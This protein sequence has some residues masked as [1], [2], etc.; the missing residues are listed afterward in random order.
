MKS[1][2]AI[3]SNFQV[4][5]KSSTTSTYELQGVEVLK[6]TRTRKVLESKYELN[7]ETNAKAVV[8]KDIK[9]SE[10]T[11]EFEYPLVEIT[12]E[13]LAEYRKSN[14]PSIVFKMDGKL[15]YSKIPKKMNLVSSAILGP[16]VCAVNDRE[17]GRHYPVSE[18]EGGCSKVLTGARCIEK[19]PWITSGY[20]TFNVQHC[21]F[22]VAC[23]AH[24][25]PCPPP[26]RKLT[27][28]Q[29]NELKLA[30]AQFIWPDVKT[31]A[32]VRMLGEK[33][34]SNLK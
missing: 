14:I 31:L 8:Y 18:K 19:F 16:H 27:V 25:R 23:C 33:N 6:V 20:E 22:V 9:V 2:T 34:L 28:Q 12:T 15:Y 21:A 24:Y 3:E 29:R 7:P 10:E 1:T 30:I 4:T 11:N 5:R 26:K 17:C 13:E 32:E